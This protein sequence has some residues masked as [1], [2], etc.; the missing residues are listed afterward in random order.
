MTIK[1]LE[2]QL[3][4]ISGKVIKELVQKHVQLEYFRL[5]DQQILDIRN[6]ARN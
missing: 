4:Y 2:R 5:E 6:G 3:S 1:P